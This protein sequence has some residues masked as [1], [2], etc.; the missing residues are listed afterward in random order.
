MQGLST[1]IKVLSQ[2]MDADS[3]LSVSD[4]V[5]QTGLKKSYVS[6]ILSTLRN[7]GYLDQDHRSNRYTVG[8]EA[9]ALGT[10]YIH[11][12]PVARPALPI[13][14]QLSELT[15]HTVYLSVRRNCVGRHVFAFEGPLFTDSRWRIGIRLALH[16]T[17]AGKVLLAFEDDEVRGAILDQVGLPALTQKTITSRKVL[18]QQLAKIRGSGVSTARGETVPGLAAMAVPVFGEKERIVAA[19]GTVAPEQHLLADQVACLTPK[20]HDAARRLSSSLGARVYPFS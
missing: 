3:P 1:A 14:R 17:A 12:H 8:L 6:K 19:I 9:F 13:M 18:N 5:E 7:E 20:L 2:F 16:A 15:G 10:R 4:V 11:G